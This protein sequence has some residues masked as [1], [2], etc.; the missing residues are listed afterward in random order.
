MKLKRIPKK[1]YFK[2]LIFVFFKKQMNKIKKTNLNK[3]RLDSRERRIL[4]EV[5]LIKIRYIQIV[6]EIIK[7]SFLKY[8]KFFFIIM[9]DKK[10]IDVKTTIKSAIKIENIN[11]RGIKKSNTEKYFTKFKV[12]VSFFLFNYF[13]LRKI[14]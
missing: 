4:F 3:K 8:S 11:P 2:R 14:K 6:I 1:R 13:F 9:R 10:K 12:T 5:K 7:K